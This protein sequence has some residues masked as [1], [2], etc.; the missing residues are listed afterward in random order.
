MYPAIFARYTEFGKAE[1]IK[2]LSHFLLNTR[3]LSR[4]QAL[5]SPPQ[6][7]RRKRRG[8]Y[9]KKCYRDIRRFSP[10]VILSGARRMRAES[11]GSR[12]GFSCRGGGCIRLRMSSTVRC[13][14]LSLCVARRVKVVG[15]GLGPPVLTQNNITSVIWGRG[16]IRKTAPFGQNRTAEIFTNTFFKVF[17]GEHEGAL[18]STKVPPRLYLYLYYFPISVRY[19]NRS[20]RVMP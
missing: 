7:G 13:F 15:E 9:G 3:G 18:L 4:L 14:A 16:P 20:N 17:S 12:N 8:F 1:F 10:C 6:K 11:N 2:T 5:L 19:T